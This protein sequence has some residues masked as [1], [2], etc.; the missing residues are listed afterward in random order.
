[1]GTDTDPRASTVDKTLYEWFVDNTNPS[2]GGYVACLNDNTDTKEECIAYVVDEKYKN[3]AW[4]I[5]T[6]G[7]YTVDGTCPSLSYEVERDGV[8]YQTAEDG[9]CNGHAN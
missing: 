3:R 1:M 6:E 7:Y 2:D 8:S 5:V 9:K 4:S